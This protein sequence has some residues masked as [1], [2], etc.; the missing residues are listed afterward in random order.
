MVKP[1]NGII[2]VIDIGSNKI[3]C[4]IARLNPMHDPEIIGIGHQI[5]QGIRGSV[6]TDIKHAENSILAALADAEKM[7][8]ETVEHVIV[9]ISGETLRSDIIHAEVNV[10]GNE[11]NSRDINR[12][13]ANGYTKFDRDSYEVI[14]CIPIDYSIDGTYGIQDPVGMYGKILGV[15][16]HIVSI[17]SSLMFN[18][19]NCLARCQLNVDDY[20]AS[21]YASGLACLTDDEKRLGVTL[22]DMGGQTTSIAIFKNN[23]IV[24]THSIPIGG[25]HVT[26]DIA[27]CLSTSLASA[28]RLKILHG[29]A[30]ATAADDKEQLDIQIVGEE[31]FHS[32]KRSELIAIIRPRLE[33]IIEM[34][35]DTLK[36][37][38]LE[39]YANQRIVLTGGAS[40]LPSIKELS[41]HIMG[42]QV[43]IA[44][45]KQLPGVAEST[46][47]PA[48]STPVGMLMF[49]KQKGVIN[50]FDNESSPKLSVKN[51]LP[52]AFKWVK[53]NF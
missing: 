28:E 14:H 33:E 2:T 45:P 1:K 6:V 44:S 50:P 11:I 38:G 37:K 10:S 4:F 35:N 40:Q 46:K 24:Y 17:S 36:E 23:N 53:E 15:D 51:F 41:S 52:R 9:N 5:S 25:Y 49:A 18:L 32:I 20:V 26:S 19:S 12:V 21:P 27:S 48:F 16:I 8:G 29:N 30:I 13:L 43:R 34:I 3:V 42:K 7:A 39:E 47:G 31:E 22:V